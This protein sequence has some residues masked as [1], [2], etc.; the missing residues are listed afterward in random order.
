MFI[1]K[2]IIAI[3]QDEDSSRLL[4]KLMQIGL[5]VTKLATTGGFLKAGNTT[6]LLGVE[7][8]NLETADGMLVLEI[9][10]V[11]T[12]RG[13]RHIQPERQTDHVLGF[14]LRLEQLAEDDVEGVEIGQWRIGEDSLHDTLAVDNVCQ[15]DATVGK[16]IVEVLVARRIDRHGQR[17][18]T[19]ILN[20]LADRLASRDIDDSDRIAVLV[21]DLLKYGEFL[22][23]VRATGIEEIKHK[24]LSLKQ[25]RRQRLSVS[26]SHHEFGNLIAHLHLSDAT[27]RIAL[28]HLTSRQRDNG[29]DLKEQC[30]AG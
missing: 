24:D 16:P 2:L 11:S 9:G 21:V 26:S 27:R 7:E 5:G 25:P 12:A 6:L 19:P 3:V 10:V 15:G 23:T 29:K 30:E 1:M 14:C 22:L 28:V 4:S 8:E 17:L 20:D 18:R 13:C